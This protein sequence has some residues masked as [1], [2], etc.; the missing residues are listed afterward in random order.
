MRSALSGAEPPDDA[1]WPRIEALAAGSVRRA[2]S[3]LN[4]D[5]LKLYE[6]IE[7]LLSAMPRVDW[8]IA[9]ALSDDLAGAAARSLRCSSTC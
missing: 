5:G 9:H 3:L 8:T 4:G 7:G 6:R 1:A 2:L